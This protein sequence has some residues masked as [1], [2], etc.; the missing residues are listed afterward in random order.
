[1]GT[2]KIERVPPAE[3][4]VLPCRGAG[5]PAAGDVSG[6]ACQGRVCRVESTLQSQAFQALH[7][8]PGRPLRL[9]TSGARR[10]TPS[11][12]PCPGPAPQDGP[13]VGPS[14]FPS[15]ETEA[16]AGKPDLLESHRKS[17]AL[18]CLR[19]REPLLWGGEWGGGG[20][21]SWL[22]AAHRRVP[23]SWQGAMPLESGGPGTEK[24]G[25]GPR[26][27][28]FAQEGVEVGWLGLYLACGSQE[29]EGAVGKLGS[30]EAG[31]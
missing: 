4:S 11:S 8:P 22:L 31:K 10:A 17:A 28:A 12:P 3:T 15:R 1:M 20:P 6:R 5:A 16:Q 7:A 14:R 23:W 19:D 24:M 13:G 21:A 30:W 26:G 27:P 29:P 18:L 2:S 25:L 9:A